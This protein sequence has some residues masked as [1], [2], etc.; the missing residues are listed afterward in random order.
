MLP[1]APAA[2]FGS[3]P[4]MWGT[5]RKVSDECR[6]C[7]FIPTH[8]GN[9]YSPNI[10]S[11]KLPV[12]PHACGEHTEVDMFCP[13]VPGSSP[14][15]WGTH[16]VAHLGGIQG[17]FIPTHVGNTRAYT[18]VIRRA[19]VHPHACGEHSTLTKED[20][21][22][23]GSSP[24]MWGTQYRRRKTSSSSRFIPTHVGN[25]I[26]AFLITKLFPVH[27]HAC[28]E[29]SFV[30]F[31][32][33]SLLG[34]SPRMWGTPMKTMAALECWRFIPTHVGNTSCTEAKKRAS[35]VHPHAC[36][37]HYGRVTANCY[38][39]GSSPRMWGTRNHT[40]G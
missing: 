23:I 32:P 3:S 21:V 9:T 37:E 4:R 34:S 26:Q 25:T 33:H 10:Q 1:A 13:F 12:H 20:R 6:S 2:L 27:P 17:R 35:T 11:C 28:G 14:R 30:L 8:V 36:G 18:P 24:R 5:L 39:T 22:M 16:L 38:P 40:R 31:K 7:R 19:A 29:H 15:M